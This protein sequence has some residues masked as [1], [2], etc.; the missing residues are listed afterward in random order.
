[1]KID[2]LWKRLNVIVPQ[3]LCATYDNDYDSII[4]KDIRE[5]PTLSELTK[6]DLSKIDERSEKE[7]NKELLSKTT[8]IEEIVEII[9][10]YLE[11]K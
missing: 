9:V 4:W 10:S 3:P 7:K 5:K 8:K 2:N 6:V 1:M 11:L